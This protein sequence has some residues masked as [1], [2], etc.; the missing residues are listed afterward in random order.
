MLDIFGAHKMFSCTMLHKQRLS[1]KQKK[2]I[3]VPFALFALLKYI[4]NTNACSSF[5]FC[6]FEKREN[7]FFAFFLP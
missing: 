3:V 1:I 5:L 2:Q 7:I 4:E 6:L